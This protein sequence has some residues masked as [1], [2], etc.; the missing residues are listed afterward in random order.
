VP[1]RWGLVWAEVST[2]DVLSTPEFEDT[3]EVLT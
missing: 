1:Q 2:L 3:E